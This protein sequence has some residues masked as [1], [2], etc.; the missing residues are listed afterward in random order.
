MLVEPRQQLLNLPDPW[1]PEA[2]KR[3][4]EHDLSLYK[5]K[6]YFYWGPTALLL[7]WPMRL[8]GY[9]LKDPVACA[10]FS[11]LGFLGSVALLIFLLRRF[12]IK[13]AWWSEA[14]A[15]LVLGLCNVTP[16]L[17]RRGIVYETAIACGFACLMNALNLLARG[18][19]RLG[20]PSVGMLAGASLLFGLSV[21]ARPHFFI[22]CAFLLIVGWW[23]WRAASLTRQTAMALFVP[24]TLCGVALAGYNYARFDSITEFGVSWQLPGFHNMRHYEK[25]AFDRVP[26]NLFYFLL[27]PPTFRN[28]FPYIFPDL[29]Y[30]IPKPKVY[31]LEGVTGLF[32]MNPFV[33]AVFAIPASAV[34]RRNR[35]L[36]NVLLLLP[37]MGLCLLLFMSTLFGSSMRYQADYTVL[38]LV[39]SL[40]FWLWLLNS[41]RWPWLSRFILPVAMVWG[42]LVGFAYSFLGAG[43]TYSPAW[44]ARPFQRVEGWLTGRPYGAVE[45]ELAFPSM[46]RE[47]EPILTTASPGGGGDVI[48]AEYTGPKSVRFC[49][50]HWGTPP[51]CGVPVRYEPGSFH[52]LR[53]VMSSLWYSLSPGN[54]LSVQW[55]GREV[56]RSSS[57]LYL[58]PYEGVQV[59]RNDIGATTARRVF[60]G[61]IRSWRR[62]SD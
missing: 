15:I 27:Q 47:N 55:D 16:F 23:L 14:F 2:N 13:T 56:L 25:I 37:A 4:R 11:S 62:A 20:R 17:I 46:G 53:I 36:A 30:N 19:L 10:I 34:W 7:Y 54:E 22:Y 38:F 28:L 3:W 48:F 12:S 24:V 52:R 21:G 33:L 40:V 31:L 58:A 59:G 32:P 45:M 18:G 39:S 41:N 29:W 60:S 43:P 51:I 35:L 50:D 8:I 9:P 57:P 61:T 6:Y 49:L 26:P 44:L 1:E 5:G 42:M